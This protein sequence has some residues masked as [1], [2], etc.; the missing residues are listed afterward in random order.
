MDISLHNLVESYQGTECSFS[1]ALSCPICSG[2]SR[3][4][5]PAYNI[6]PDLP[7]KFSMRVC[8]ICWHGYI[9]PMPS[10]GLLSYLYQRGSLSVVGEGW[11]N[12]K[13]VDLTIP[14]KIVE[15]F[16]ANTAPANYLELGVGKGF[17]YRRF[18]ERGWKCAGVEPGSWGSEL[19]HIYSDITKLPR[20]Y[21]ADVLV[22]LDVLEHVN[23]PV[24]T[25]RSL[26]SLTSLAG[27][28]YCAVPNRESLRARLRR[29]GWRMVRPIGHLHYFSKR[30]LFHA[31]F[32]AGFEVVNLQRTDLRQSQPIRSLR[33]GVHAAI[34]KFGLGD[35]WIAIA[36]AF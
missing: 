13:K 1:S 22:A 26:R 35:Q 18:L 12:V 7:Y 30:S 10:Q 20:P 3:S 32:S 16:E 33:D 8:K 5:H 28:L 6:H 15:L 36:R 29:E 19:P 14:E 21:R 4:T 17:L 24:G 27:R 9:D 34:E 25:L 23:D 11:A 31:M 2:V